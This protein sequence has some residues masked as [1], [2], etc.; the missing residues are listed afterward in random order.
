[1]RWSLAGAEAMIQLRSLYLSGDID[2]YWGFH[3]EQEGRRLYPDGRR[4]AVEE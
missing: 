2:V 1:M 3:L 4:E